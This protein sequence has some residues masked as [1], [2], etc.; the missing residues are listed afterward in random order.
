MNRLLS[1]W[2]WRGKLAASGRSADLWLHRLLGG[3]ADETG[4]RRLSLGLDPRHSD[5]DRLPDDPISAIGAGRSDQANRCQLRH[6]HKKIL[7]VR[8]SGF[9]RTW[10]TSAWFRFD[11]KLTLWNNFANRNMFRWSPRTPSKPQDWAIYLKKWR[12]NV[13]MSHPAIRQSFHDGH[14]INWNYVNNIYHVMILDI[15]IFDQ[16]NWIL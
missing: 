16:L 14:F 8:N 6:W 7:P 9:G 12:T 10:N 11:L 15:R 4:R 1:R 3:N 13:R 2:I 5:A